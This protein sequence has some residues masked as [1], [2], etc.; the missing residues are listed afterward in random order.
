MDDA[1]KVGGVT[2]LGIGPSEN[3]QDKYL[4]LVA[5]ATLVIALLLTN[6]SIYQKEQHIA[7]GR[8]VLLNLA[9]VDPRSLM[10]GDY[11]ALRFM[12]ENEIY[13]HHPRNED[14]RRR[15]GNDLKPG[16]GMVVVELD[17]NG[18]G[19]FNALYEGQAL[20]EN[21]VL[22]KYRIRN[23][24]VKF[25]TNAFFF[26]EGQADIYEIAE[27]GQFRVNDDGELLLVAMFDKN[28]QKLEP[29]PANSA[30]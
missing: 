11:M 14:D 10:Q 26:E 9:P 30:E 8:T 13:N 17:E 22:M 23:D 6:V 16:D 2:V 20:K 12:V 24:R 18:V 21:Q 7:H 5:L 25:A 29:L 27:Y 1:E 28:Y 15:W 3:K 19:I 4:N